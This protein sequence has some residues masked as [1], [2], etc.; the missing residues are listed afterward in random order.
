[1]TRD[2]HTVSLTPIGFEDFTITVGKN[3]STGVT[4]KKKY[5]QGD[6]SKLAGMGVTS[7]GLDWRP[8]PFVWAVDDKTKPEGEFIWEYTVTIFETDLPPQHFWSPESGKAY[9]VLWTRTYQ[10]PVK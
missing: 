4:E 7:G 6:H 3:M 2:Q 8:G 9:R 1:V 5:R 10:V